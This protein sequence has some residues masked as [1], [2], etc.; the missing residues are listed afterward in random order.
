MDTSRKVGGAQTRSRIPDGNSSPNGHV[1]WLLSVDLEKDLQEVHPQVIQCL[2]S[3]LGVFVQVVI[4]VLVVLT[5]SAC[6]LT[7][8]WAKIVG[9][10]ASG[11]AIK[12]RPFKDSSVIVFSWAL[13]ATVGFGLSWAIGGRRALRQC[14][15]SKAI[16]R[17]APAGIGWALADVCEV[18]ALAQID[19]AS[20]GV[21]SQ[22]RLLGAAAASWGMRGVRQT[23]L[24]WGLLGTLSML[25]VVYCMLPDDAT[26]NQERLYRWRLGR[27]EFTLGPRTADAVGKSEDDS[28]A[29][30]FG[31]S[32]A[33][34]KVLLS[35]TSGVYG[36]AC[37]KR[38]GPSGLP[39][40]LHV[41]MTQ[42]SVS[43]TC[44]AIFGYWVICTCSDER[45]SEFF[46]GPDGVWD[47]RTVI[48]AGIYCWREWICNYCA[49]RF[50]SLVKNICNAAA[51]VV[52]YV[53]TVTV[54]NEKPFSLLKV[55]LLIAIVLEIVNYCGSRRTATP[56]IIDVDAEVQSA[57][58]YLPVGQYRA[59]YGDQR[60]P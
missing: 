54:A 12:G 9:V 17:F 2:R 32:L 23:R 46:S 21:V 55:I 27:A 53:F 29:Q 15:D 25:C 38:P 26:S 7:V 28:A 4:L 31:F 34:V 47:R 44:A 1:T 33:L 43:S 6:P 41:Q 5:Y 51:L 49:K 22:A 36:E 11:V 20:Y 14:L 58:S 60:V 48:V 18:L 19:A 16:I 42:I 3:Q 37:F 39:V 45:S 35:V 10:D 13:I 40:D 56:A 8:S 30:V 59:L 52:T 50:D 24:Q 57:A